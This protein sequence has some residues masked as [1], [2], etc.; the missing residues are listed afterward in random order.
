LCR[1]VATI[2]DFVLGTV[3]TV[4]SANSVRPPD[5]LG[6]AGRAV[7]RKV[8]ST[9]ELSAGELLLLVRVCRTQDL[10]ARI[11]RELAAGALLVRGSTGQPRPT[12]LLEAKVAQE[13]VLEL[14]VRGLALPLP[15]EKTGRRRTPS[16]V[17][18]FKREVS[19][20]GQAGRS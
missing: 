19:A 9:Y 15:G 18:T 8:T 20:D 10:L 14:L 4:T 5:G 7:W 11:D 2:S 16:Q 13:R 12:P 17:A 1:S 6:S 3:G